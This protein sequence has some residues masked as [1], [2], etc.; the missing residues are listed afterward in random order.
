MNLQSMIRAFQSAIQANNPVLAKYYADKIAFEMLIMV[1]EIKFATIPV[2][3]FEDKQ[4]D[5]V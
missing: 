5:S 3:S 2:F 4:V 1:N